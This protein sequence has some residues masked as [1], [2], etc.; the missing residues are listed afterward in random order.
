[1]V[2]V[3]AVMTRSRIASLLIYHKKESS[4]LNSLPYF[5]NLEQVIKDT[6]K[7]IQNNTAKSMRFDLLIQEL[8]FQNPKIECELNVN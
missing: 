6:I 1:M 8:S 3:L 7:A 2:L 5:L 4:T